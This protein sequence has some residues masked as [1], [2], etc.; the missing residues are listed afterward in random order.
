MSQLLD[1]LQ[2]HQTK[3]CISRK[4]SLMLAVVMCFL[5]DSLVFFGVDKYDITTEDSIDDR[6]LKN[7][8]GNFDFLSLI[9]SISIHRSKIKT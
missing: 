6:F 2:V 5:K 8:T 1:I 7:Y 9:L 3:L 4:V